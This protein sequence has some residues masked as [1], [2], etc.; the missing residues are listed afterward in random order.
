MVI[1]GVSTVLFNGNPLL[2]F[3]GYYVLSD[4]LDVPNLGPRSNQYVGYLAQRYLLKVHD[5]TSPVTAKGEPVLLL[6]LRGAVVPVPL[7]RLHPDRAL[8]RRLLV[9]AR[10]GGGPV[11]RRRHGDQASAQHR[12][13]PAH[14]AAARAQPLARLCDRG[15]HRC[16]DGGGC[17]TC[18]RCR[19]R[20]WPK[21][22]YGCPR[23]RACA[24]RPAASSSEVHAH[25]GQ[26]VKPGDRPGELERSRPG[27]PAR[28]ACRRA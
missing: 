4:V 7:V 6:S 19:S 25:D 26:H 27:G 18:C 8:G 5:A 9:L 28:R 20:P 1:G 3:D 14:R 13:V 11:H 22:W 10:R 23:R 15:R 17:C 21:A 12:A 2:R 16:C 24:P